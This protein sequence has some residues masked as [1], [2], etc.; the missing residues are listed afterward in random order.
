[1]ST[2]SENPTLA[3]PQTTPAGHSLAATKCARTSDGRFPALRIRWAR[4]RRLI[5]HARF[6][7]NVAITPISK[8]V[9]LKV[10][11]AL[12]FSRISDG[13]I[14]PMDIQVCIIG[15]RNERNL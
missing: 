10:Q 1:M 5:S 7:R 3:C 6:R 4:K 11:D 9:H 2:V 14:A 8:R 12:L 13:G 15:L